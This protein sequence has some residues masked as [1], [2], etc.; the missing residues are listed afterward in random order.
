MNID[1]RT[2]LLPAGAGQAAGHLRTASRLSFQS[3]TPKLNGIFKV[4]LDGT[5]ATR[6]YRARAPPDTLVRSPMEVSS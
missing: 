3:N 1:G 5:G 2:G 6:L 4:N